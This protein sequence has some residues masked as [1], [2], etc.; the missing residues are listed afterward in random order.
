MLK[1]M[2]GGFIYWYENIFL[3]VNSYDGALCVVVYLV[4]IIKSVDVGFDQLLL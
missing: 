3:V 1:C 4:D 2:G